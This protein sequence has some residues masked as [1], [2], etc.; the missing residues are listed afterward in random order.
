MSIEIKE[1]HLSA[2]ETARRLGVTVG[3]IYQLSWD[4]TLES[5]KFGN[6]RLFPLSAVAAFHRPKRGRKPKT[7]T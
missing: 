6:A 2:R 4:G 5:V 1:P 7:T 3:R